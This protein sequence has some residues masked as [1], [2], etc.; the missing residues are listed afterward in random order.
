MNNCALQ[1][2][3]IL[4][5][6]FETKA[7]E[8][9]TDRAELIYKVI[10]NDETRHMLQFVGKCNY[11]FFHSIIFSENPVAPF[12]DCLPESF[13]ETARLSSFVFVRNEDVGARRE[14]TAFVNK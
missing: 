10:I 5:L 12:G 9:K 13:A 6:F 4:L 11:A 8:N 1:Q 7:L 2:S 14:A 3:N